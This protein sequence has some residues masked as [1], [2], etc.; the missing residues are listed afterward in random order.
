MAPRLAL[1]TFMLGLACAW[2]GTARAQEGDPA[3]GQ[4]DKI[5]IVLR[6]RMDA[7]GKP[8]L[9]AMAQVH[10]TEEQVKEHTNDSGNHPDLDIARDVLESDYQNGSQLCGADA[11][12]VCREDHGSDMAKACQNLRAGADPG[13]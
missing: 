2:A 8:C 1:P 6:L 13:P 3:R 12:R 4:L 5:L 10:A 7:A 9:D 11:A